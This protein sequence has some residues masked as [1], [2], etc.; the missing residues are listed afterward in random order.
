MLMKV[1]KFVQK[2]R[3]ESSSKHHAVAIDWTMLGSAIY[4]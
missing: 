3:D 2:I 1:L 4:G